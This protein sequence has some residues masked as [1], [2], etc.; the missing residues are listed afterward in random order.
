MIKSLNKYLFV[1]II[2]ACS[3]GGNSP[4]D[5]GDD[6]GNGDNTNPY[7]LPNAVDYGLS[8]QVEI[9]TWNI[10]Q[11]PQHSSTKDYVKNLMEK[12]DADIYFLQEMRS[13][14]ELCLLYTSDAADD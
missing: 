13:E 3:S 7:E 6:N 11:F 8:N 2:L 1:I 4:T 14:S 5:S 9:V 12:W 10:R